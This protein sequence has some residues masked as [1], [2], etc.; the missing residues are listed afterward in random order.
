MNNSPGIIR[1][2]LY[3]TWRVVDV[4]RRL[5]FNLLFL[6]FLMIFLMALLV[7]EEEEVPEGAA[8]VLAPEGE[9]VEQLAYVPPAMLLL[10]EGVEEEVKE[11]TLLRDLIDAIELAREDE[12]I[13][14]MVLDLDQLAVAGLSKLQ[15]IGK[16]LDRFEESGKLV[17]AS[18][19]YYT[20]GQYYLAAH[21]SEIYL[22]PLG[23]VLLS[24][25]GIY[26]TYMKSALDRLLVQV[27]AFKVGSY[28]S[29]LE[30][31]LRD[32]MSDEAREANRA[33][34]DALWAA[35]RRDVTAQRE[36]PEGAID[37]YA[38]DIVEHLDQ[39]GGDIGRMALNLGLVD[40]LKTRDQ[41]RRRL[42]ELVG[43]GRDGFRQIRHDRYLELARPA[44]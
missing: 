5:V 15:E 35:Y 37:G 42:V 13:G 43:A 8:L 40:A 39:T 12:R 2:T 17:I 41:V 27:H 7:G 36:L 1:R 18:G 32:D 38:N 25:Y 21:A 29:A 22:H 34:L 33:W 24:G 11:E 44:P 19:D 30:P 10:R 6:F 4:T 9:I 16:A 20:Q 26:P 3:F 14:A 23:G 28:K 31:F